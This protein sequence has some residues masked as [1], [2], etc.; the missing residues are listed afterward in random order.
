MEVE[1]SL[2]NE[3]VRANP[4]NIA[5]PIPVELLPLLGGPIPTELILGHPLDLNI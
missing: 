2:A 1:A 3:S 5:E 4:V